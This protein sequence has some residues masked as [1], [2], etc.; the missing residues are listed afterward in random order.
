[1]AGRVTG[2]RAVSDRL[3][4]PWPDGRPHLV[5][6]P[7]AFLRRCGTI[8]PPRRHLVR[9]AGVFGPAYG[10]RAKLRALVPVSAA[11][12][13]GASTPC[14]TNRGGRIPWAEL[15]RRVFAADVLAYPCGGRRPAQRVRVA[16]AM[17]AAAAAG[18]Q[19]LSPAPHA[20]EITSVRSRVSRSIGAPLVRSRWLQGCSGAH[21]IIDRRCYSGVPYGVLPQ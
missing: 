21:A 5:L 4:R 2:N 1:M 15:L 17:Q 12:P 14:G 7:V 6:P 8:P 19:P 20:A 13:S 18:S 11:E 16:L 10:Q 3:K 9:Y